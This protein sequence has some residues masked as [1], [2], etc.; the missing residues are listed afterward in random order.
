VDGTRLRHKC[1]EYILGEHVGHLAC[2]LANRNRVPKELISRFVKICPTCK[3][4]RGQ[5]RGSPAASEKSPE[6]YEASPETC[7]PSSRRDSSATKRGSVSVQSPVQLHGSSSLFAHQN[8]WMTS[9]QPVEVQPASTNQYSSHTS[10]STTSITPTTPSLSR[11]DYS[12]SFSTVNSNGLYGAT[13]GF[14]SSNVRSTNNWHG[15][16]GCGMKQEAGYETNMRYQL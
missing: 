16:S 10:M 11:P 3:V 4:R 2:V 15:S 12:M 8:R 7:S 5:G 9:A 1:V 14:P 6:P 13:S